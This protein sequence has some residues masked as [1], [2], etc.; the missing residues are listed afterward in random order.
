MISR[1]NIYR[2][3]AIALVFT[4]VFL[5]IL[6]FQ[7]LVAVSIV[8]TGEKTSS[9]KGA[10]VWLLSPIGSDFTS[11]VHS[12][13]GWTVRDH[14]L[15]SYQQQPARIVLP[16][17]LSNDSKIVFGAHPW[18]GVV[19]I[20]V[21]GKNRQFDLYKETPGVV[22]V[23]LASIST[24]PIAM[25]RVMTLI[26][27][28]PTFSAAFIIFASL[29]AIL[30]LRTPGERSEEVKAPD[31]IRFVYYGIPSICIYLF[32]HLAFWP[33]QMSSDSLDQWL[34]A[35]TWQHVSDA[36]PI[37]STLLHRLA[38][39]IYPK[40]ELAVAIQY[41]GYSLATGLILNEFRLWGMNTRLIGFVAVLFPLFP[42]NFLIVTT[43]WKDVP[44]ATGMLLLAYFGIRA[45][46]LNFNL[47]KGT[48]SGLAL[49]SFLVLA[50]R[51]NGILIT[52]PFC[53]L[54]LVLARESSMK[55]M[56]GFVIAIQLIALVALK[57]IVLTSL[58]ADPVPPYYRSI[59]ALHVLGAAISADARFSPKEVSILS[60]VMPLEKWKEGY[61]CRSVGGLFWSKYVSYATLASESAALNRLALSTAIQNPAIILNHQLCLTSVIWRI[62]PK[63][64]ETIGI[65]PLGIDQIGLAHD[66][67]LAIESKLPRL[68]AVIIG[69]HDKY[70]ARS[71]SFN[72]AAI[73]ILFGIF[74]AIVAVTAIEKR[75]WIIFAP[76][77]LNSVSLALL[78]PAPDYR[79]LWPSI[80]G[81]LLMIIFAIFVQRGRNIN[82]CIAP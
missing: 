74:M 2:I 72:R 4:F 26:S 76:G 10:E 65:S 66:Q 37:F 75:S 31:W 23:R 36:H 44:F 46:R 39:L 52:V 9:S 55:R 82:S 28:V 27:L 53:I 70:L 49:A 7:P 15:V 30:L 56:L 29:A 40:P 33:G 81:S 17:A 3:I 16:M 47:T 11:A 42:P 19:K 57:T 25:D 32:V 60:K 71:A 14:S 73:F 48:L 12:D 54:L 5:L 21:N 78:I 6:P 62:Q 79:Y 41:I 34:Q 51:H 63:F 67:G 59:Y 64:D 68:R 77:I 20:E 80:V 8:A 50:T 13:P 43:L 69:V 35:T 18:S 22:E 1:K 38:Y 45:V 58:N 61:D 24:S